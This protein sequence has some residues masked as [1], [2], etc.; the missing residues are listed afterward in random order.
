VTAEEVI[1]A[2]MAALEIDRVGKSP[3]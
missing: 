2:E 3:P 1:E